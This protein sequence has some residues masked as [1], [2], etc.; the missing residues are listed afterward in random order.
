MRR[1]NLYAFFID[2]GANFTPVFA[3][4]SYNFPVPQRVEWGFRMLSVL[5][6]AV[7]VGAGSTTLW[8]F[9]PRNGV[10]HPMVLKPF[11]DTTLAIAVMGVLAVGIAL[12]VSGFAS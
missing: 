12:I 9:R 5:S 7:L 4:Q 1:L 3:A 11:F 2:S 8:W 10:V 6:G